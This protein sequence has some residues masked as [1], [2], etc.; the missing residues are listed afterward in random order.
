MNPIV[1]PATSDT[2]NL[3]SLSPYSLFAS[4]SSGFAFYPSHLVASQDLAVCLLDTPEL[5]Q[6]VPVLSKRKRLAAAA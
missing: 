5:P 2:M 4:S 1:L 6:E 3:L